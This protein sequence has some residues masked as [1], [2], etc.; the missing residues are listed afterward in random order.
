MSKLN[1]GKKLM[2]CVWGSGGGGSGLKLSESHESQKKSNV[3]MKESCKK[4]KKG[5]VIIYMKKK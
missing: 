3:K 2:N 5:N 4:K 1:G